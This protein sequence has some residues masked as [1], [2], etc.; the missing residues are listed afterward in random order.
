MKR[1]VLLVVALVFAMGTTVMAAEKAAAPVKEEAVKVEKAEEK[2]PAKKAAKKVK[3]AKK[4]EKKVEKKAEEAA[5]A[6]K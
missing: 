6:A 2:A 5:P 4:A 3:K 1:L